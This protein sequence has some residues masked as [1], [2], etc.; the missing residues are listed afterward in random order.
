MKY[1]SQN[2]LLV[3]GPP[4]SGTTFMTNLLH[5][6]G[7]DSGFS[8][9]HF[10]TDEPLVSRGKGLEFLT[11]DTRKEFRRKREQGEDISP[12]LIKKPIVPIHENQESNSPLLP[13]ASTILDRIRDYGW[14]IDQVV[15]TIRQ[16]DDFYEAACRHDL[17][18]RDRVRLKFEDRKEAERWVSFG[19]YSLIEEL[20]R[21]EIPY[22]ILSF[23]KCAFDSSYTYRRLEFLDMPQDQ[24][25]KIFQ[26]IADPERV[27]IK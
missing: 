27:H 1:R 25:M 11:G 15:I 19:L 9:G 8:E 5:H 20:A 10:I 2:K 12:Y 21:R 17:V 18:T 23:P 7:F 6:C 26:N 3:T 16:F 24:F 4:S 22:S 13:G 14:I